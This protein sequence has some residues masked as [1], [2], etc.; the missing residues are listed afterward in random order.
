MPIGAAVWK[1]R[2]EFL[3]D[4][5]PRPPQARCLRQAPR[6]KGKVLKGGG[7]FPGLRA[8]G[9]VRDPACPCSDQGMG[10]RLVLSG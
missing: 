7:G 8:P 3:K 5:T 10:R 4:T 2:P 6:E 9:C 1:P